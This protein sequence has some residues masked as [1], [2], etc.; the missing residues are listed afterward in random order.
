MKKFLLL[1]LL[2][3]LPSPLFAGD[4]T[5]GYKK[6]D[7]CETNDLKF[8]LAKKEH[9]NSTK[10]GVYKC[11]LEEPCWNEQAGEWEEKGVSYDEANSD[12]EMACK[13]GRIN[14]ANETLTTCTAM[15]NMI[16]SRSKIRG[17]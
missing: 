1:A 13:Y 8:I 6:M 16:D 3:G 10:G 11:L 9:T 15:L 7:S 4:S 14:F 5:S 2:I 12:Y 17:N